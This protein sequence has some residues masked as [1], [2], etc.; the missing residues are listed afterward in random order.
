MTIA[1]FFTSLYISWIIVETI[2]KEYKMKT[3]YK[4][5]RVFTSNGGD[6]RGMRMQS[7]M[8]WKDDKGYTYYATN[9]QQN[10]RIIWNKVRNVTND[11]WILG[12]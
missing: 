8:L 10:N 7:R 6:R 4:C 12:V 3:K 2:A 11:I 1:I 5:Q 9:T